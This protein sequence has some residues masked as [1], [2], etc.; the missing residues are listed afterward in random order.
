MA[1][2]LGFVAKGELIWF[3][4]VASVQIYF[5]GRNFSLTGRGWSWGPKGR[6]PRPEGPRAGVEFLGRG[7]QAPSPPVDIEENLKFGPTWYLKI[8]YRNALWC[9]SYYRKAKTLRGRK[10]TLVPVFFIGGDH[11]PR[12]QDRRHWFTPSACSHHCM[13]FR[14]GA[15]KMQDMQ[16]QSRKLAQKRQTSELMWY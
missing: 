8:H 13:A 4:P 16:R 2:V 5:E 10:D 3:T 7:Q 6:S 11:L 9:V 14:S 1:S 15:L 12:P